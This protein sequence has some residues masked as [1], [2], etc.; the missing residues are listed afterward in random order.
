MFLKNFFAVVLFYYIYT[1]MVCAGW[2]SHQCRTKSNTGEQN[3]LNFT[4]FLQFF[5]PLCQF[6]AC[7]LILRKILHAQK[8]RILTSLMIMA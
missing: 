3:L 6:R 5:T 8:C 2:S 7:R 1:W 4:V